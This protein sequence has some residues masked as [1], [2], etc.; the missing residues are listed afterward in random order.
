MTIGIAGI[1]IHIPQIQDC[2][3][4]LSR[5]NVDES[6]LENKTG[7]VGN[8]QKNGLATSD[9]CV[10]AAED[11]ARKRD[12]SAE[13][14][15]FLCVCTQNGDFH[16]PQTSA[17]VHRKLGL[18]RSCAAFDISLGCS[19]YVYSLNVARAFMEANGLKR[20]LVFTADPY[21]DIIDIND[22]NT[23]LLFGDAA[24]VTL[25]TDDP[26]YEIGKSVFETDGASAEALQCEHGGR[27]FMDGRR[28]FEFVLRHV[29][30]SVDACLQRNDLAKDDITL[31]LLHQASLYLVKNAAKRLKVSVD[32]VPF[33]AAEYGN[34][35][36]SSVPLALEEHY[37]Q[38][39]GASLLLSG[40]GVGLSLATTI[41]TRIK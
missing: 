24:T 15:D 32:K 3:E 31:F 18:P 10:L 20:G 30:Q 6:F 37:D 17:L 38:K 34:T 8:A 9:L 16:L 41:I 29:P 35:V 33:V 36:S 13:E 27:L 14:V 19:G 22:K 26:D 28:I 39:P 1:G 40:F 5:H 25:M 23:D 4:K 2:R 7:F 11:L 21:S 12:F